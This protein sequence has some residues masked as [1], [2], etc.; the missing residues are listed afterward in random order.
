VLGFARSQ[1]MPKKNLSVLSQ[2]STQ[3]AIL[4]RCLTG[5]GVERVMLNLASSLAE[6]GLKIDLVLLKAEGINLEQVNSKVRVVDLNTT[7]INGHKKLKSP[8]GFQSTRSL[9]KLVK[10]LRREQPTVLLAATHFPNE[11]AILAKHLARVST[12]VVVSE[13]T[14][15]SMEAQRVEQVSARVAPL[16]ARLL[17]P[18]ADGIIAVS[19]GVAAD[20]SAV[21][22]L[23][24]KRIEVIYNPVIRTDLLEQAQEPI[25]HPWFQS[26]EPPVILG[27]GRFVEQK[28]FSTLIRAFAQVRQVRSARLILLGGGRERSRLQAL[29]HELGVA[30]DVALLDFVKNPYPYMK[31][32]AVFALSSAWEGLPT[33]LIEAMA[34]QVPIVATDCPFGPAEVLANGKYGTLVPVGDSTAIAQE[35]LAALSRESKPVASKWCEQFTLNTATQNYLN[36]LEIPCHHSID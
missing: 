36:F 1:L 30:Q 15:L 10:Y 19:K 29:S 21:T 9:L 14:T 17:Y 32:A 12:R 7:R 4:L 31:R 2:G 33:V 3:I 35:I 6:Q 26:G 25:E 28:S 5:G 34:L 27:V 8:T 23:P 24:L 18:F 22:G 20:L 13:H 11:V 16:T